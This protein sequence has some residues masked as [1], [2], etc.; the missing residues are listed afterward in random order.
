MA[1]EIQ[2]IQINGSQWVSD[3]VGD[4]NRFNTYEEANQAS[5]D[6]CFKI[7]NDNGCLSP[8]EA[9]ENFRVVEIE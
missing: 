2:T 7:W 3:E 8:H 9:Y 1:Y 5:I 6:L 4:E